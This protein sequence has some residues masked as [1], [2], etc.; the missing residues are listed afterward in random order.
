MRKRSHT[1]SHF[2]SRNCARIS[3]ADCVEHIVQVAE[4]PAFQE[5]A[6][7]RTAI[8]DQLILSKVYSALDR[9][10]GSSSTAL[11]IEADVAAGKVVLKGALSDIV[12]F[13]IRFLIED[14]GDDRLTREMRNTRW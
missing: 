12:D 10:F 9:R 5:T 4:A 8:D 3:V 11:G 2:N 6:Q 14:I 1:L 7:S 13:L